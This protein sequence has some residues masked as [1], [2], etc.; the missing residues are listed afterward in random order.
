MSGMYSMARSPMLSHLPSQQTRDDGRGE[1]AEVT[2][3][4][5]P[6]G[7]ARQKWQKTREAGRQEC[8][9]MLVLGSFLTM[10]GREGL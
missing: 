6:A 9:R 10:I 3:R 2:A 7:R 5:V 1:H 4:E 8:K